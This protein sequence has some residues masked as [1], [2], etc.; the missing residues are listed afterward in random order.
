MTLTALVAA[1]GGD[2][3]GLDAL[4]PLAG[5]TVIEHQVRRLAAAGIERT[6]LLVDDWPP[7]LAGPLGRLRADGIG[8]DAVRSLADCADRVA[9]DSRILILAD[10]CLPERAL[11]DRML[12]APVPALATLPDTPDTAMFERI[13]A[14]ARWAGVALLDGRRVAEAAA[15]LGEWDPISTMLRRAVQE[16]ATRVEAPAAPL[17]A[18]GAQSILS[19]EAG[20]VA[21]SREQPVG[22]AD[23]FLILPLVDLALPALFARHIEPLLPAALTILLTVAGGLAGIAGFRWFALIPFLIAAPLAR[24]ATRLATVQARA[25]PYPL[26]LRLAPIVGLGL[27]TLG[28]GLTLGQQ[29]HQWGWYLVAAALPLL[30]GALHIERRLLGWMGEAE[31]PRWLARVLDTPWLMLPFAIAGQW[32]A[33]LATVG[34]YALV[35]LGWTLRR[36]L[37]RISA[38]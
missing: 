12:Q 24:M 36:T 18:D 21:A 5:A 37:K 32:G 22:L 17:L 28:L 9:A 13:D 30:F 20:L 15:M 3:E 11:I 2:G 14:I 7:A 16:T 38:G 6:I 8:V 23:R 35:S 34:G 10:A 31:D 1:Y 25:L 19:A 4:R 26:P 29:S 33:G 27:A